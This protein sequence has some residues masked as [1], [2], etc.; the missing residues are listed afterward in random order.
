MYWHTLVVSLVH[1]SQFPV[2]GGSE[3]SSSYSRI[4][5]VAKSRNVIF[6]FTKKC[7]YNNS[8][9]KDENIVDRKRRYK[10]K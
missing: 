3:V 8:K 7:G 1:C 4:T 2:T 5:L 6:Q 9:M 10:W